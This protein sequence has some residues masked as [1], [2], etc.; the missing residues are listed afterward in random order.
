MGAVIRC[1][2]KKEKFD[3]LDFQCLGRECF[4]PGIYQH[5]GATLSGSR[6]TG[7]CSACC[8]NRAYHG[9]PHP[10]PI[11]DAELVKSRKKIG[12]KVAK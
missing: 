8:M 11:S 10:L 4:A 1:T 9:C 12:W 7:H 5:R 3:F 2:G 6:A